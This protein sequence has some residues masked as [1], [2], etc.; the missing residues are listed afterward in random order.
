MS[1]PLSS[2][3]LRPI[4]HRLISALPLDFLFADDISIEIKYL[5]GYECLKTVSVRLFDGEPRSNF[6]LVC[7]SSATAS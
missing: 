4:S 3:I 6:F 1:K 7:F 2:R 5:Y